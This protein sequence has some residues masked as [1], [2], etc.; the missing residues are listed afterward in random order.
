MK[1][2]DLVLTYLACTNIPH[3]RCLFSSSNLLLTVL[4]E[5][6]EQDDADLVICADVGIQQ[7]GHDGPH[8]VFDLLSL[9]ICA[10]SQILEHR[11][12]V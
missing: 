3:I 9:S 1:L 10:H 11:Q 6:V 4:E 5:D 2:S 7:D 8:G 12:H